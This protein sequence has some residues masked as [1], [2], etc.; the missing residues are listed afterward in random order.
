[1]RRLM[2][3]DTSPDL[4]QRLEL[5]KVFL[6]EADFNRLRRESEEHLL[7]GRRVKF[8]L[9]GSPPPGQWNVEM[10]VENQA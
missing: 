8:L 7:R 10:T 2:A 9:S 5:L 3:G 6:E 4:D 1:M